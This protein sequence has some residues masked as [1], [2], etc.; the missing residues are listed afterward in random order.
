M[1]VARNTLILLVAKTFSVSLYFLFGMFIGRFV[2]TETNGVYTTMSTLLAIGGFV[3]M[4]GV[5]WITTRTIA[6]D[7][8][9]SAA[10]Y[11]DARTAMLLGSLVAALFVFAYLGLRM[12]ALGHFD[13]NE[14]LLGLLVCGILFFDA[15]GTVGEAVC[16][17]HE[18]M[19]LP[20]LIEIVTGVIKAGLALLALYLMQERASEPV[21]LYVVYGLFLLGSAARGW[22]L[23]RVARRRFIHQPLPAA[24][25]R[26]ARA[27]L[28]ESVW[29]ALFQV[30]RILR[31]RVDILLLGLLVPVGALLD[32]VTAK[33]QAV[34]LYG[35][36]MRVMFVFH[37]FTQ[38]FN[39][40]IFPRMSRL[41]RDP[42]RHEEV[43]TQYLRTVGFQAWWAAPLA[44][45]TFVY[46]DQVA[47]WFGAQ[48]RDGLPGIDGTTAD[49]LRIVTLAMLLDSIGGPVG[50]LIIGTPGNE[51][52]L[53]LLGLALVTASVLFNLFLIPRYGILGAAYACVAAAAVEFLAKVLVVRKLLREP[54]AMLG[55]V[56]PY[57]L[58]AVA[59][60]AALRCTPLREHAIL[61]GLA[62]AAVYAAASWFGGLLDPGI[63]SKILARL[64]RGAAPG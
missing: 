2:A 38:A 27:L 45:V 5:P 35:Q 37:I 24:S 58:L 55:R 63:K 25:L 10:C 3:T 41:T 60:A 9:A 16:Q 34:G 26:R 20:G 11:V 29:L 21:K 33:D 39:Q 8:G 49:V 53:P 47:G 50:M 12:L 31:T 52:K 7:H 28:G 22:I 61:G 48:Y 14:L 44:A 23:P 4:F 46:A 18:A 30:L 56:L 54:L 6:R 59:L 64:G 19:Q 40:A 42:A 15:H 62:L 32:Q 17:G 36:A 57:L 43:R 1:S 13:P 51:R